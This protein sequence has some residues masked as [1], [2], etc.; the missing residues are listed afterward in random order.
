MDSCVDSVTSVT[1]VLASALFLISEVLPFTTKVK[2][3]GIVQIISD[4][5]LVYLNKSKGTAEE[6]V[7][8]QV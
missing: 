6:E 8:H 4:A 1:T 2:G 3:N 7:L 5:L